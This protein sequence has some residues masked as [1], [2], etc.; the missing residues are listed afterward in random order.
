[1]LDANHN[2]IG[3]L[4]VQEAL[5]QARAQAKDLILIAPR[6]NPPVCLIADYGRFLFEQRK[7]E[8]RHR[9]TRQKEI[10]LSANIS[11]HD[12]DIKARHARQFLEDGHPV[13]VILKL[14]GREKAHPEIGQRQMDR[15]LSKLDGAGATSPRSQSKDSVFVATIQPRCA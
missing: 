4:S 15:F 11:E 10:Q 8:P 5:M 1:V 14:R 7:K 13:R 9:T 2:R 6:A 3:E 12:L